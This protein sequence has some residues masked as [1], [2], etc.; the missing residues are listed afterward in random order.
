MVIDET[1]QGSHTNFA[2]KRLVLSVGDFHE[3]VKKPD[4]RYAI[5]LLAGENE[6]FSAPVD[7]AASYFALDADPAVPYY[8][9]EVWDETRDLRIAIGNPIWND[10]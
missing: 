7:F 10:K 6:V 2:G 4:H 9:A 5:K 8:R 3:S 1:K